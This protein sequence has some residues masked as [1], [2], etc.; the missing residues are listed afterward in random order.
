MTPLIPI[1]ATKE[2]F[3]RFGR[4]FHLGNPDLRDEN[5]QHSTGDG[6][7]DWYSRAPLIDG[8]PSLGMTS[9]GSLPYHAE[10]MERHEH[11]QEALFCIEDP[12]VLVVAP[13]DETPYPRASQTKAFSIDTGMVAVLNRGVWHDACRG[14]IRPCRYHWM[15]VCTGSPS[16]WTEI[17][18]GPVRIER[19]A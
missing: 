5:V 3:A 2:N 9:T 18:G 6:W 13:G 17:S 15:A 1:P 4:V 16:V 12:I 14:L 8:K 19:A 10:R 11:T 7:Q